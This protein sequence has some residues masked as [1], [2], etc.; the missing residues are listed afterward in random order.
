MFYFRCIQLLIVYS[1]RFCGQLVVVYV[2][3]WLTVRHI[4]M[5]LSLYTACHSIAVVNKRV[6]NT[7]VNVFDVTIFASDKEVMF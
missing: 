7:T 6:N 4:L 1:R 3:Y 2:L 5:Q